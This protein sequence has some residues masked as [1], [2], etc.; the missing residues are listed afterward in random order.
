MGLFSR[1]PMRPLNLVDTRAL[2]AF[3][4]G[5]L[6]DEESGLDRTT[7]FA[8]L[9]SL[10]QP[11][12]QGVDGERETA[13]ELRRHAEEDEWATLGAWQFSRDF[14]EDEG[15][16]AELTDKALLV[17]DGMRI[18]NLRLHLP[19]MDFT[20]YQ[21]LT[22]APPPDDGFYG[23]PVFDSN[24]GP[25]R[26]FYFDQAAAAAAARAPQRIAFAPGVAP[27]PL[28]ESTNCLWDFGML[29][30][31]GAQ[32][33]P[34]ELRDEA[35]V[36]APARAAATDVDHALVSTAMAEA[37]SD[38][39]SYLHGPWSLLGCARFLEDYLDPQ[40]A[41]G[42]L[43]ERLVDDGLAQLAQG[44]FLGPGVCVEVLSPYERARL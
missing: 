12:Y 41:G 39:D 18:T 13:D 16:E 19:P 35:T 28:G 26:Q 38:P 31:R 4:R 36:L 7:V 42:A 32:T 10:R 25:S 27:A 6:L 20:R 1:R 14:L 3:G 44:G 43:H 5:W 24:F 9:D 33:M 34:R 8:A 22:G 23:P 17:L 30:L 29:V 11:I 37:V 21:E 15:L 2:A 40:L